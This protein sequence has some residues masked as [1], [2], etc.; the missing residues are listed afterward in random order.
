VMFICLGTLVGDLGV[1]RLFL[2]DI[3]LAVLIRSG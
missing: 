1:W 3:R 2:G